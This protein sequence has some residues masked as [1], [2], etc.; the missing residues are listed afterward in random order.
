MS[1]I[2]Q[3]VMKMITEPETVI[4]ERVEAWKDGIAE[5]ETDLSTCVKFLRDTADAIEKDPLNVISLHC[6]LFTGQTDKEFPLVHFTTA[7][8]PIAMAI[9]LHG[10]MQQTMDMVHAAVNPTDTKGMH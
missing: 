5:R 4:K 6:I 2:D 3:L 7:G 9:S 1:L 8:D 10:S